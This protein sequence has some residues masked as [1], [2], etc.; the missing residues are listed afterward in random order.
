MSRAFGLIAVWFLAL[1]CWGAEIAFEYVDEWVVAG[2]DT[3]DFRAVRLGSPESPA[4][5]EG[6][7][8]SGQPRTGRLRVSV[9]GAEGVAILLDYAPGRSGL[10]VDA[11]GDARF[12][13]DERA[14]S[15][16]ADVWEFTLPVPQAGG[17]RTFRAKVGV[18]GRLLMYAVRGCR[19]GMVPTELGLREALLLD[20]NG[21]GVYDLEGADR[22]H[23]DMD[24]DGRFCP[25]TERAPLRPSVHLAGT[26]FSV[27]VSPGGDVLT[28]QVRDRPPG[29][30]VASVPLLS[31][32]VADIS[33]TLL[34]DDGIAL[35]V[36]RL[37]EP[38]ELPAG[39]YALLSATLRVRDEAGEWAFNFQRQGQAEHS[40]S[41]A[42]GAETRQTFLTPLEA[43]LR[44]SGELR[45]DASLQISVDC[46]SAEGLVLGAA[47][48]PGARATDIP[49]R[50]WLLG[51]DGAVLAQGHSSYG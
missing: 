31:G 42:A 21:D 14:Q 37:G 13:P 32:E 17:E 9:D 39:D 41:V 3:A 45:P 18:A 26:E 1:P 2:V 12:S 15:V 23:V 48:A 49:V 44:V 43:R 28:M 4:A 40:L 46:H 20:G 5:L 16:D 22:I 29:T 6:L 33:L 11:D 47:T 36:R 27:G 19:R 8:L 35:C 24:A 25:L 30:L 38:V 34:R 10:Y 7:S 51:P 50:G